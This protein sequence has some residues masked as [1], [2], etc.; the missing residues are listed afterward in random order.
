[1]WQ[2]FQTTPSTPFSNIPQRLL[3]GTSTHTTDSCNWGPTHLSSWWPFS[4]L[5]SLSLSLHFKH[6]IFSLVLDPALAWPFLTSSPL[7]RN[8]QPS[9]RAVPQAG[10]ASEG[11]L[12]GD[13]QLLSCLLTQGWKQQ[14]RT[15][16]HQC[17]LLC[18][19][20]CFS[21]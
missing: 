5:C 1:M 2:C 13:G 11:N 3:L 9:P 17:L 20:I 19:K 7:A 4:T 18:L 8:L 10:V 15:G 12:V 21:F 14:S 6:S 16:E